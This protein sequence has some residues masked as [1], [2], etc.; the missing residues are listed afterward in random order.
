MRPISLGGGRNA[1]VIRVPW[2]WNAP[3]R[4]IVGGSNRFY[5]RNSNGVHE[6]SLSELRTAFTLGASV[7]E[8]V[9]VFRQ[10]RVQAI[11]ADETPVS[12]QGPSR[13]V[14]HVIPLSSITSNTMIEMSVFDRGQMLFPPPVDGSL[15]ATLNFDGYVSMASP[16]VSSGA[17][18]TYAQVFRNGIVEAVVGDFANPRPGEAPFFPIPEAEARLEQYVR[19]LGKLGITPPYAVAL[20]ALQ[21]KGTIYIPPGVIRPRGPLNRED[22]LFAPAVLDTGDLTGNW[23]APLKPI[24]EALWNSFGY[25][26]PA[27]PI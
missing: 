25:L 9:T 20:S 2:S 4:V 22:L 11:K 6:M 5:I 3:H 13:L 10:Q 1:L 23:K 24:A 7:M 18:W 21:V 26:R 19:S 27:I 8:R 16:D 15:N 14:I 12:V 17:Y